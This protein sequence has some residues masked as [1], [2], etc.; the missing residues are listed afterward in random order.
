MVLGSLL[1]ERWYTKMS[2]QALDAE[3]D[4]RERQAAASA[5]V[6][7][8]ARSGAGQGTQAQKAELQQ[9]H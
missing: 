3:I 5:G 7:H 9:E 4:L 1:G 6:G 2:R 8:W